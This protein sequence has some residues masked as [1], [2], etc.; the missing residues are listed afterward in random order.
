MAP[1]QMSFEFDPMNPAPQWIEDLLAEMNR[2]DLINAQTVM[3][4]VIVVIEVDPFDR[5]MERIRSIASRN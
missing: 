5:V 1:Q 2:Q 4:E 3:D